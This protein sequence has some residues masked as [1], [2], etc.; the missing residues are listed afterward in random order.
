[1]DHVTGDRARLRQVLL[2]LAGNA[3]KFTERGGVSLLVEPDDNTERIRFTIRDTGVGI[4]AKDQ[5][6]IFQDFEQ[7]DGSTTRRFGGTGLGLAISKRIVTALGGGI[8][9]T[10]KP[11][12]GSAFFVTLPLIAADVEKNSTPAH[13]DLS[14]ATVL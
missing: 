10:S 8:S 11:G 5:E 1:P 2:N 14:G 3:I 4:E 12:E 9:L 7:A 6:R 13:P